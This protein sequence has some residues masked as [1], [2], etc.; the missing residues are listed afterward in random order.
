[1]RWRTLYLSH[2]RIG[3]EQEPNVLLILCMNICSSS[4]ELVGI[5]AVFERFGRQAS[6]CGVS[7]QPSPL[8]FSEILSSASIG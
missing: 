3:I 4:T 2:G 5:G 6:G 8:A 7:Q 1:M